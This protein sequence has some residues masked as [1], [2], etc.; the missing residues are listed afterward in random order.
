MDVHVQTD[1]DSSMFINGSS[2]YLSIKVWHKYI[3]LQIPYNNELNLI[4]YSNH[5]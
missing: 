2:E 4:L 1:L 3:I 5:S